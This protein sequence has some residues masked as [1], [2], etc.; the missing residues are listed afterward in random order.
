MNEFVFRN[1][2]ILRSED[3]TYW[4]LLNYYSNYL[5]FS[6]FDIP[7]DCLLGRSN[8]SHSVPR[9]FTHSYVPDSSLTSGFSLLLC[10]S[11]GSLFFYIYLRWYLV[12][13]V[14]SLPLR[15]LFGIRIN[16]PNDSI[17]LSGYSVE[18]Y[19]GFF[20]LAVYL[21]SKHIDSPKLIITDPN[22]V[23][24][25]YVYWKSINKIIFWQ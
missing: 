13:S 11:L 8:S 15:A 10:Y 18:R 16:I 22:I 7:N 3:S 21:Q 5:L 1:Y 19:S 25:N 9:Y 4:V 12:L 2:L 6:D 20:Y 23:K 14:D 17:I 24:N